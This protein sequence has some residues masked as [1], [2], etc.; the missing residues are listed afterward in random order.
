MA[1]V[2]PLHRGLFGAAW[3]LGFL[4]VAAEGG[5]EAVTMAS[6]VG[7]VRHRLRP[8]RPR[9]AMVSTMRSDAKVYPVFHV[10][11]GVAAGGGR[12]AHRGGVVRPQAGWRLPSRL[13]RWRK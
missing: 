10:L 4:S 12:H 5:I 1:R 3:H 2:D 9:P 8:P 6:P 7:R 11:R 13:A